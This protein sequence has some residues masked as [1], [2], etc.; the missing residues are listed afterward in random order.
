[1]SSLIRATNLRGYDELVR[2]RGGDPLPLL[3]RYRIAAEEERDDESFLI[4]K[5]M[6]ALFEDTAEALHFPEFGL[7]LAEYQGMDIL[8]PISVIGRSSATV[9]SAV[10]SIA[11]YLPLHCSALSLSQTLEETELGQVIKLSYHINEKELGSSI[12]AYELGMSNA[13]QVMKLLCG[14]DFVPL[15]VFFMHHQLGDSRIYRDVFKCPAHFQQNWCGFYLPTSTYSIP[16]SSVDHQ[17][18][19]LAEHY[20]NSQKLPDANTITEDVTRL[21]RSLLPTGQCN[22]DTVASSLSMHKRT[23]QRKLAKENTTFEQLLTEERRKLARVYLQEPHMKLSQI[24]G[25][26]G[27]S[28]QSALNRV[29][30]DWFGTTPQRLRSQLRHN[31]K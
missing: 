14:K 20:L 26:L 27:Y 17:T 23:L 29:C 11:R 30:R 22:N 3:R 7:R 5:D 18:W 28:E 6:M 16:L 25:L 8:G 21:I 2:I 31:R 13:M 10:D 15:G 4:F 9:G 1:M 19:Q 24:A 12:Q